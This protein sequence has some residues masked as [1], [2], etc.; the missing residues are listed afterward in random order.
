MTRVGPLGR[1]G[2]GVVGRWSSSVRGPAVLGRVLGAALA[3][4]SGARREVA[5]ERGRGWG[6][7]A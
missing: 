2:E 4:G 6:A 3:A 7:Q 5:R 1:W